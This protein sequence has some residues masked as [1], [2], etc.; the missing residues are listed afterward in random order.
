MQTPSLGE[1]TVPPQMARW[2]FWAIKTTLVLH[3]CWG[4]P[5]REDDKTPRSC[6]HSCQTL[7]DK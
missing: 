2:T 3:D 5:I 6:C 1:A 7:T 4:L